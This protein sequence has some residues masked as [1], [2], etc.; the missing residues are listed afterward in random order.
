MTWQPLSKRIAGTEPDGPYE[1][2]PEHLEWPL[3]LWIR[4][5]LGLD[6]SYALDEEALRELGVR[7][8]VSGRVTPSMIADQLLAAAVKDDDF[9]FDLIDAVLNVF[10]GE[11]DC[12]NLERLLV[13]GASVW[14]VG[15]DGASLTRIVSEEA[16][17]TYDA[18]TSVA[19]EPS[20][21]LKEAW[22]NAFGRNGDP[23]DAWDHAIKAV[24][25][26]LIPVMMQNNGKATLGNVL[27]ELSGQNSSQW[28]FVL[29]G[30]DKTHDVA[31]LV[32]MLRVI[33]PNHDRHGGPSPKR[34][35][36]DQEARAV[37]TLA[38]MIVQ[39]HR[40]GWVVRKR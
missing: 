20:D 7:F 33:W 10:E 17:A 39:W 5:V 14:R 15:D 32:A 28:E 21:E 36:S 4:G 34:I 9:F 29:P 35:P 1:G 13:A 26:V 6:E 12:E 25:D 11:N 19:D 38:A 23:S 24:E 27:G 3:L 8:R 22:S 37:V 30:N 40:D 2:R 18:A 16:Q 31:P